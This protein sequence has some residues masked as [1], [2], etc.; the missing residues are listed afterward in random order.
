[1]GAKRKYRN[2]KTSFD[3]IVFDSKKEATRYNELRLM[4]EAG[5]IT[6]LRRQVPFV[7]IPTQYTT[8][9]DK[10]G[11][12]KRKVAE[13]KVEYIADFVYRDRDRGLVVEDVK[14][15]KHG[16]GYQL[17]VIKRKLMLSVHHIEVL[18]V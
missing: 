10:F 6:E 1:M 14:G 16:A 7:L 13:R 18:E 11:R 15:Y 4:Q 3:G 12:K 8:V 2:R 5:I 9:L 17:F